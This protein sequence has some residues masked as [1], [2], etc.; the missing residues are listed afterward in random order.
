MKFWTALEKKIYAVYN[1]HFSFADF[2]TAT[3]KRIIERRRIVQQKR[4]RSNAGG[5]CMIFFW[6][7]KTWIE[8]KLPIRHEFDKM[9]SRTK[10]CS[11]TKTHDLS[12]STSTPS[13][14]L[15]VEKVLRLSVLVCLSKLIWTYPNL[16][17]P[18][19]TCMNLSEPIQTYS[20]PS[21]PILTYLCPFK[22]IQTYRNLFE[23]IWTYPKLFKPIQTYPNISKLIW[24]YQN[25][26]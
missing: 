7:Y 3:T 1:I 2:N 16:F 8:R 9:A 6:R 5:H 14:F 26:S 19:Q 10:K 11:M 12:M 15:K 17:K 22:V 4:R 21:K 24:T 20:N 25:L 23:L 13:V 18:I